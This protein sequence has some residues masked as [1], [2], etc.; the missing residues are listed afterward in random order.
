MHS[1]PVQARHLTL[2][3]A[4][5]L[6]LNGLENVHTRAMYRKALGDFLGWRGGQFSP[7]LSP[8]LVESHK[9]FLVGRHYSAS[10]INQRLAAIRRL[11]LK[12]SDEGLLSADQAAT[13]LRIKGLKKTGT[14]PGKSLT[15]REAEAL[16]NAPDPAT[17][18]GKR[19]RA[20]LALLVGCG[21]R[22]GEVVRLNVENLE[23]QGSHWHLAGVIGIHGRARNVP[24]PHWAKVALDGWLTTAGI[25]TGPIFRALNHNGEPSDRR[26]SA[27]MVL[28]IVSGYGR[29]TGLE[30][31]PRDLRR[32]CAE[33]CRDRGAALEQIQLLL[34]H[35]SI[36]MTEQ[37]LGKRQNVTSSPND[38]LGLRWRRARRLAS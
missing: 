13:I 21:L 37:L 19:D 33:L 14:M 3:G 28:A 26:L 15:T 1:A 32:T 24:L 17:K 12:A 8:F 18:K 36:Q 20:L 9:A 27:P 10:S 6:V 16:M 7:P 22:R 11:A 23:K 25:R 29:Q 34:G 5:Q 30:I 2:E 38:R 31:K 4:C 35:S